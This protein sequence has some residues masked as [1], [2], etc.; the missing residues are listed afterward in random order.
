MQRLGTSKYF[1][2]AVEIGWD[3]RGNC[4]SREVPFPKD[5]YINERKDLNERE[6]LAR[7]PFHSDPLRHRYLPRDSNVYRHHYDVPM[8]SFLTQL[9]LDFEVAHWSSVHC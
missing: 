3:G 9:K 8:F 5:V 1:V 2:A 6:S 7:D 4:W